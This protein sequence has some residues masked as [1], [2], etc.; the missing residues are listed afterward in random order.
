MV[1]PHVGREVLPYKNPKS[2]GG[3]IS[4]GPEGTKRV[5][6]ATRGRNGLTLEKVYKT[7]LKD[8]H[9]DE[10]KGYGNRRSDSYSKS[11]EYTFQE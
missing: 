8:I 7:A 6:C 5:V 2:D 4:E 10:T 1:K 11:K 9:L 3:N